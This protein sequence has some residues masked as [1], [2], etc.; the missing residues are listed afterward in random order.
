MPGQVPDNIEIYRI[1]HHRNLRYILRNGIYAPRSPNADHHYVQ[2]GNRDIISR[3]D[4]IPV[5][6][7]D[8]AVL[9]DYVAFYFGYR[10]P[11]LYN[12][13]T[14]HNVPRVDQSEIIYIC[15][16]LDDIA[17]SDREWFFTD[18][19]AAVGISSMYS[20]IKYLKKVDWDMVYEQDWKNVDNDN[21]R[22]RR[23]MAECL[24]LEHVPISLISKIVVCNQDKKDFVED[25]LA[26]YNLDI[27]VIIGRKNVF[28][29]QW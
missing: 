24:I 3:R 29:Y 1:I 15:C 8:D 2:I 7:K 14:G 17:N 13:H 22:I 10:S 26:H 28:Y 9:N 6:F 20:S 18:G 19:N 4:D 5:P 27:D 23:K 25:L 16:K 21:D 12:I 11:M